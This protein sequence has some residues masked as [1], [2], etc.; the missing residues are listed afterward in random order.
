M[1]LSKVHFLILIFTTIGF[2]A[3]AQKTIQP[4]GLEYEY[5]GIV[6]NT[7]RAYELTL[8]TNGFAAAVDFGKLR[9]YYKTFYYH[10][11]VG[12]M[13]HPLENRQNKNQ[14]LDGL[15]TSKSFRFGK[16]NYLYLLRA[17][18]GNKRY[19]SEKTKRRGVA[20]GWNYE[21]GP[22]IG[23]LRPVK[24]VYLVVSEETGLKIPVEATYADDPDLF[25]DYS[26]I[27]GRSADLQTV[28]ESTI[29]PGIQAKAGAHFSLGAFEQYV[30]AFEVG[31]M[32]DYFG[33]KIPLMVENE[34]HSNSPVFI[35]VYA[36]IHFGSRE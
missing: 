28:L 18:A 12:Y 27:F 24:N 2:W 7:E 31:I 36:S 34:Q 8:H 21:V 11:G 26:A 4:K 25:L 10:L 32:V 5:K 23:L 13:S 20:V 33:V 15:G 35:N 22:V 16:Q 19:K 17:G 1:K 9:T 3:G 6:Y 30:R 14:T 29:R